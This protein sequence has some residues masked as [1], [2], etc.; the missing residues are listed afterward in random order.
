[1]KGVGGEGTAEGRELKC[2]SLINYSGDCFVAHTCSWYML[3]EAG[4]QKVYLDSDKY[5]YKV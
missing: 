3:W 4:N 5:G 1:M 2:S